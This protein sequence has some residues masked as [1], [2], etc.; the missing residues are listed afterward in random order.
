M[1]AFV[2]MT[3]EQ[4]A[5]HPVPHKRT[6]LV[7]GR[8]VVREPAAPRHGSVAARVLIEIGKYL[9]DHPVGTVYAAETGFTLFRGPDTVRAPDV[10]FIRADRVPAGEGPGFGD[11]VPDL[12]VEVLSPGDRRRTVETKVADW[13]RAGTR[14]VWVICPRRRTVQVHRAGGAA[15]TLTEGDALD[16]EDVLP[17]FRVA[18]RR[19]LAS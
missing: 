5:R 13:L 1:P 8:L 9:D 14:L 12:V 7:R 19:L 11:V 17:G 3:A 15:E 6:E 10:A 16:G 4:L 2:Y 18:V